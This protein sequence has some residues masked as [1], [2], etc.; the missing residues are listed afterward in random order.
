MQTKFPCD[1]VFIPC[2]HNFHNMH[3]T[4][5]FQKYCKYPGVRICVSIFF[6]TAHK[7]DEISVTTSFLFNTLRL[8]ETIWRHRAWSSLIQLMACH[9]FGAKP[10]PEPIE[11]YCQ[12]NSTTKGQWNINKNQQTSF[13]ENVYKNAVCNMAAFCR[14]PKVL[15]RIPFGHHVPNCSNLLIVIAAN[16]WE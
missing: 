6:I 16:K 2:Q 15:M 10:L 4:L 13:K 3:K 7:C 5:L 9:L 14:R 1:D 12:W 8:N 11:A